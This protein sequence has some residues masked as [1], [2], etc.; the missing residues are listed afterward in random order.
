MRFGPGV[1]GIEPWT[2]LP[3]QGVLAQ[4]GRIAGRTFLNFNPLDGMDEANELSAVTIRM[5]VAVAAESLAQVDR[6]ADVDQFA[7][8]IEHEVNAGS[9]GQTAKKRGAKPFGQR[10]RVGEQSQLLRGHIG[11][12]NEGF[13]AKRL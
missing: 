10:F 3:E 11:H 6:L 9:L 7:A 4:F 13:F 1:Q 5:N 2:M 8:S 12:F